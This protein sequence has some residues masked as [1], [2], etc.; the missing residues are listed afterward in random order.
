MKVNA[1][2]LRPKALKENTETP[3]SIENQKFKA[4]PVKQKQKQNSKPKRHFKPKNKNKS[5]K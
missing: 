3:K 4:K 5:E 2:S 1:V